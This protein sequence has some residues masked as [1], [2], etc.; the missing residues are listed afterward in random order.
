MMDATTFFVHPKPR[1]PRYIGERTEMLA[2]AQG[3]VLE[4]CFEPEANPNYYSPWVSSASVVCPDPAR[5]PGRRE[6]RNV[7]GVICEQIFL[8]SSFKLPFADREFDWSF[9]LMSLCRLRDPAPILSEIRRVLKPAG[10]YGFLEHGS[11]P[12]PR[13]RRYQSLANGAWQRFGGCEL[14]R[15]IDA[16]IEESGFRIETLDRF[17]LSNPR[18]LAGVYRGKARA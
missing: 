8:G 17:S 7:R 14:M 13:L 11:S 9:S 15:R 6:T 18:L 3:R 16:I 1:D 10:T 5:V 2:P 12:D 4:L